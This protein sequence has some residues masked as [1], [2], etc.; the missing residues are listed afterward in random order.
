[1]GIAADAVAPPQPHEAKTPAALARQEPMIMTI[2]SKKPISRVVFGLSLVGVLAGGAC[3]RAQVHEDV[4]EAKHTA[5]HVAD[6]T[7]RA[8]ANAK[9]E[10]DDV[11]AKV[12][13]SEQV[14]HDFHAMGEDVKQTAENAAHKI[15]DKVHEAR[16]DLSK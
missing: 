2:Q 5:D 6:K 4:Q 11:A 13:S 15:S 9:R 14:K 16:E 10:V 3:D 12:P 1:M 8:L 7:E